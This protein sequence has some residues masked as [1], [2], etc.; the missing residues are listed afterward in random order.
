ME[1]WEVLW[2]LCW[3]SADGSGDWGPVLMGYVCEEASRLQ[4]RVGFGVKMVVWV[5]GMGGGGVVAGGR[6]AVGGSR[7]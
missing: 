6:W 2:V 7:G 5:V 4:R 3:C 1:L